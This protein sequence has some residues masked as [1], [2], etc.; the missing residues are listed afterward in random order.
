M[1]SG[2]RNS[3]EQGGMKADAPDNSMVSDHFLRI[4]QWVEQAQAGDRGAFHRIVDLFQQEIFRMI[5][6]RTRSKMDAED[7]TQDVFLRAYKNIK[8]IS[9]PLLFRPWLYQIAVNRVRDHHRR[10]RIKSL[11]GMVSMDEDDFQETEAMAVAPQAADHLARKDFWTRV[12]TMVAKL[13][14]MER[15]VFLLRFFDQLSIK[16]ISATLK[17]NESTIKTHLYRALGKVRT[18]AE[19]DRLW[20]GL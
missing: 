1:G 19:A 8:T 7:L 14:R 5:Y 16:E 18:E 17:K 6:Y 13:S 3:T 9:S 10:Q 15:E 2:I 20:E 4:A 11:V 12:R